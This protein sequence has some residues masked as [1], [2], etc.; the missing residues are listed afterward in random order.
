[1]ALEPGGKVG[2]GSISRGASHVYMFIYIHIRYIHPYIH[3]P[4]LADRGQ[5]VR[6][7]LVPAQR[8][9]HLVAAPVLLVRARGG[10]GVDAFFKRVCMCVK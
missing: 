2:L 6:V 5:L 9:V 10:E 8:H 4:T 1:M 7:P 3:P